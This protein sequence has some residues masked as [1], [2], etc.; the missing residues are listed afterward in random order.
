M[1]QTSLACLL[2]AWPQRFLSL[3]IALLKVWHS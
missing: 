1:V 3:F 2:E